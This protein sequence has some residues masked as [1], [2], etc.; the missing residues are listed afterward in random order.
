MCTTL[1]GGYWGVLRPDSRTVG[2]KRRPGAQNRARRQPGLCQGGRN[3]GY[4]SACHVLERARDGSRRRP[5]SASCSPP[6]KQATSRSKPRK[7]EASGAISSTICTPSP[8]PD[9]SQVPRLV[10]RL[11]AGYKWSDSAHF[12]QPL[13][14]WAREGGCGSQVRDD[15]RRWDCPAASSLNTSAADWFVAAKCH[16]SCLVYSVWFLCQPTQMEEP[17]RRRAEPRTSC[18]DV[19]NDTGSHAVSCGGPRQYVCHAIFVPGLFF[20][21]TTWPHENTALQTSS[22]SQPVQSHAGAPSRWGWSQ[23][24]FVAVRR[25]G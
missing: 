8:F 10:A 25:C 12:Q 9:G 22:E 1:L 11:K 21:G 14:S 7:I 20:G 3:V 24:S 23:N 16:T 4:K 17:I 6:L 15:Q 5:D 13:G 18:W 2:P 19:P